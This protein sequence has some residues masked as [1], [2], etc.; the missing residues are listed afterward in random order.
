MWLLLIY[1]ALLL[2]TSH[3]YGHVHNAPESEAAAEQAKSS[4]V[5]ARG[6]KVQGVWI[7]VSEPPS[8]KILEGSKPKAPHK[9]HRIGD[10]RLNT[11]IVNVDEASL[12]NV[13]V[14]NP[15][16][17]VADEEIATR[18]KDVSDRDEETSEATTEKKTPHR[19]PLHREGAQQLN[20]APVNEA[21]SEDVADRD[22]TVADID[23]EVEDRD[24]RMEALED[25]VSNQ[26]EEATSH[27]VIEGRRD[28]VAKPNT[29]KLVPYRSPLHH[30]TPATPDEEVGDRGGE[31]AG[32]DEKTGD[33]GEDVAN[34]NE[35]EVGNIEKAGNETDYILKTKIGE[36]KTTNEVKQLNDIFSDGADSEAREIATEA[37]PITANK[38]P[39]K[40]EVVTPKPGAVLIDDFENKTAII[41]KP[42]G[43]P[44][45]GS[46]ATGDKTQAI[47]ADGT[48]A[49]D[50]MLAVADASSEDQVQAAD[51]DSAAT[52]DDVQP[53]EADS[54]SDHQ[55]SSTAAPL[56]EAPA[57]QVGQADVSDSWASPEAAFPHPS[58]SARE[59]IYPDLFA[60]PVEKPWVAA[61][62]ALMAKDLA[63]Q[64]QTASE[65]VR[66]GSLGYMR[67]RIR[68]YGL[69]AAHP[70][71]FAQP[72]RLRLYFFN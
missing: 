27:D 54:T 66:Q 43:I 70:P 7:R 8:E 13:K 1:G 19:S 5:I 34:Q 40:L 2:T 21:D 36:L 4:P 58:P 62:K 47:D 68:Q 49:G 15:V 63:N 17:E 42:E 23:K 46:T 72:R 39:A 32:R 20:R 44:I 38:G 51:A 57:P 52:W 45:G 37:E 29:E 26:D 12:N 55:E 71:G 22:E 48:A 56:D 11:L 65:L 10:Q 53:A 14:A 67:D 6:R 16:E 24:K 31:V 60:N 41:T 9:L 50:E 64:S 3:T 30:S 61:R 33:R 69:R 25:E 18:D 28:D 35:L 59:E